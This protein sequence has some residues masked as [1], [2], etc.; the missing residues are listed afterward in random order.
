MKLHTLIS[1]IYDKL[2][3]DFSFNVLMVDYKRRQNNSDQPGNENLISFLFL[4][5]SWVKL[6]MPNRKQ[7]LYKIQDIKIL[8]LLSTQKH[9]NFLSLSS[10]FL[11]LSFSLSLSLSHTH[12]HHRFLDNYICK[13]VRLHC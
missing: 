9:M 7:K 8:K 2:Q 3:A 11:S 5:Y 12:T 6:L 1:F 10:L 13:S 4:S